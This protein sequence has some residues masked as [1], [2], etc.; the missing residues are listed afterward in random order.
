LRWKPRLDLHT[1][2]AWTVEWSK[3]A[4]DD[5]DARALCLKQIESY[6]ELARQ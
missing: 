4:T 5:A 1:A 6:E 3:G 2:L